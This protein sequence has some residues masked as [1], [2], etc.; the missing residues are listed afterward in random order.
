MLEALRGSPPEIN[1]LVFDYDPDANTNTRAIPAAALRTLLKVAIDVNAV[2]P[3]GIETIAVTDKGKEIDGV[4]GYGAI[5]VGGVKM[6]IHKRA[7]QMLF[8]SNDQVLEVEQVY[9]IGKQL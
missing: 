8:E 1:R 5:G 3:T 4:I 6:K 2:S 9:R 7:I